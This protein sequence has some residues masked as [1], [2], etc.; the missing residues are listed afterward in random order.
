MRITWVATFALCA[1]IACDRGRAEVVALAK[2]QGAELVAQTRALWIEYRDRE[3]PSHRYPPAIRALNQR[4]VSVS[5]Y[6]VFIQTYERVVEN[7][8]VFIRHDPA[9]VP[10]E[11]GDPGFER[12]AENVYW[13]FAPG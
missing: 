13:Y 1:F 10:P 5:Q 3:V 6:G 11:R 8:G 4:R 2:P 7:A 9:Y 12:I